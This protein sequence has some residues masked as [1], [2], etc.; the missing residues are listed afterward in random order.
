MTTSVILRRLTLPA[1]LALACLVTWVVAQRLGDLGVESAR[2]DES[3]A[4]EALGTPMTSVRR[5]PWIATGSL[6]EE[7]IA[8]TL[9]ALPEPPTSRSCVTVMIDG[10]L[11]YDVRGDAT[12]VT[13]FAQL[14]VTGHVALE[15]LGPEYRFET[16]V[17]A[18]DQPNEEG[19]LFGDLFLIGGG[20]PVLMT[21]GYSR[22]F[23]PIHTTRTA[24][25]D[26]VAA[27]VDAGIIQVDGSIVGVERRYDAERTPG[28]PATYVDAGVSGP[29]SALQL[30]DGFVR[31]PSRTGEAAIASEAPAQLA[32]ERF[33][34][35]LAQAGIGVLGAPRQAGADEDL[36][37]LVPIT[38][39]TSPPLSDIVWQLW[40]VNDA[41]AAEMLMKEL[42]L[43]S[44]QDGSTR[45]GGEV[46]QLLL[47]QQGVVLDLAP[48]DGSGLD[49][50]GV[51]GCRAL[52]ETVASIPADHPTVGLLPT[53][54][55]P[56]VYG[57]A[58]ADVE[59]DAEVR[60]VGGV[61]GDTASFVATTVD[62]G[63]TVVVASIVNRSGG[64]DDRDIGFHRELLEAID[65]LRLAWADVAITE[66]DQS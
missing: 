50:S 49:P 62:G 23:R 27:V 32:A 8:L 38:S 29:L 45:A 47:A 26:L 40:A 4:S 60:L 21:Y 14:L 3:R 39:V 59:V 6:R 28:W 31:R 17:M 11:V 7:R 41:S 61:T 15:L 12:L 22:G 30:D 36:A 18:R 64:P 63:R 25:E 58:L 16:R 55:L 48:R 52:A 43:R 20:D 5:A 54:D 24:F 10:E 13:G 66:G 9:S 53:T 65:D 42:G 37:D 51:F 44:K 56:G 33:G 46:V 2:V 1:A 19:R 34:A 57:G 35:A